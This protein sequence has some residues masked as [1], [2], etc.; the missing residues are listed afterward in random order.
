MNTD[1]G[2]VVYSNQNPELQKALYNVSEEFNISMLELRDLIN[3]MLENQSTIKS[4]KIEQDEIP[5]PLEELNTAIIKNREI[6]NKNL[7]TL[8]KN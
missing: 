8:N 1:H 3:S 7:Q 6:I 4:I 2:K 5:S